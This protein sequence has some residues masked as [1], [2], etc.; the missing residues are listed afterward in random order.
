[1]SLVPLGCATAF[2]PGLA[3]APQLS[4]SPIVDVRVHDAIA[5]GRDSCEQ[6]RPGAGPLR[7]EVPACAVATPIVSNPSGAAGAANESPANMAPIPWVAPY[8]DRGSCPSWDNRIGRLT[9]AEGF[10]FFSTTA[11]TCTTPL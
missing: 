7:N 9:V 10:A 1:M 5:N 3:N 2:Q 8:S 6:R 4:G 11:E